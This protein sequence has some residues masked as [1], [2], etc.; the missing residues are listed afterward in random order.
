MS[1]GTSIGRPIVVSSPRT[2][3]RSPFFVIS[4]AMPFT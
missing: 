1:I 4:V 2:S 3:S